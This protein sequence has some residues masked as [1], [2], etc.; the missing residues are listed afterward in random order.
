[1]VV[2]RSKQD[3]RRCYGGPG[4]ECDGAQRAHW[5]ATSSDGYRTYWHT[6]GR[7]MLRA[8]RGY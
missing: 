7:A 8:T 6:W 4:H 1:M 3:V 5:V 2:V